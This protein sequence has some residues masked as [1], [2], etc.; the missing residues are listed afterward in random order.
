MTDQLA[1]NTSTLAIAHVVDAYRC[2]P[3]ELVTLFTRVDF[4]GSLPG[5]TLRIAI[6]EGLTLGATRASSNHDGSLPHLVFLEGARYLIWRCDRAV[7]SGERYEYQLEV[8]VEP[9]QH[10][11]VLSSRAVVMANSEKT[12]D[13]NQAD[14][15]TAPRWRSQAETVTL[16]VAAKSRYLKHLPALYTDQDEFMGRFLMLFDSFWE[17]IRDRIDHID[18]YFDPKMTPPDLLPWLATW[19]DLVLDEQWPEEKRRQ[20]L[21]AMVPLYRRRGTRGGLQ[22][23]L[24]IYTGRDVKITEHRAHNFQIGVGTRLG[25]SVA[26]GKNN[27]PHTFTVEVSVAPASSAEEGKRRQRKIEAIIESE[28]PAHTAYTLILEE[29][30]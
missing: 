25:H 26:L 23:Y 5:F 2:Y 18:H 9:T 27:L 21:S 6:P 29:T 19:V 16:A 24:K 10:D 17:P 1:D 11:L 30:E 12:D 22:D 15:V 14:S 8:T 13:G 28:K 20:L 3:G 7:H 4:F